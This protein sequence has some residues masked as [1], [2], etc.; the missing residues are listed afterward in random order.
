MESNRVAAFLK[1]S[2]PAHFQDICDAVDLLYD[3]LEYTKSD[4]SKDLMLAQESDDFTLARE[5]LNIQETLSNTMLSIRTFLD[6]YGTEDA[7][8]GVNEKF[9]EKTQALVE[10]ERPDYSLYDMDDTVACDIE[11]TPVTF[12]KPAAFSL[13]GERYV[14]TKWKTLLSKLTD[15][16]Y[17]KNPAIIRNMVSEARQPGRKRV[18]MSLNKEEIYSPVRIADSDIW[19]ETNCSAASIRESVLILLER[20]GIPSSQM[21][22]YFRRDYAALHENDDVA[23]GNQ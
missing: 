9:D 15:L 10:T 19:L 1:T 3:E 11:N 6:N 17:E 13:N 7:L 21:K 14:V 4:L 16:L 18:R 12:R 8:E 22:V 23:E 20:Y 2:V 5:I